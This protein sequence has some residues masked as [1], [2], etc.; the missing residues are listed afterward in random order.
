MA[1]IK[2]INGKTL[3]T[4]AIDDVGENEGGLYVEVY[5]DEDMQNRI[6][7]FTI[8]ADEMP[9]ANIIIQYVVSNMII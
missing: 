9:Y 5:D 3:Y 1:T 7:Y 6:D 2:T 4:H 8:A